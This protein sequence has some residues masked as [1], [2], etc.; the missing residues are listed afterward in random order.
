MKKPMT[1]IEIKE[2]ISEIERCYGIGKD[3]LRKCTAV[4]APRVI[5]KLAAG[6]GA[7]RIE[8]VK[9]ALPG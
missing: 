1:R 2:A 5:A 3:V 4:S 9:N 6:L 7:S 8:T